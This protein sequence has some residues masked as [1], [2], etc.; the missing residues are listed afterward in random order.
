M[1]CV[2]VMSALFIII[3][4]YPLFQLWALLQLWALFQ[5]LAFVWWYYSCCD[6]YL[7]HFFSALF[8]KIA[9]YLRKIN[10]DMAIAKSYST[11]IIY[12]AASLEAS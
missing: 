6:K 1:N 7:S 3:A 5:L 10:D 11:R 9:A 8:V 4:F 2:A 12:I